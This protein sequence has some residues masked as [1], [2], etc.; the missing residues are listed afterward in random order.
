[1]SAKEI[2]RL[3]ILGRV[4]ERRLTQWQ[5][6]VQ[7]GLTERQAG[8]LCRALRQQEAAGL[9]FAQTRATEQSSVAAGCARPGGGTRARAL[10]RLRTDARG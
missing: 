6:G 1:M 2:D 8:R 7:L 9:I 3:E 10:R 4:A 5:A